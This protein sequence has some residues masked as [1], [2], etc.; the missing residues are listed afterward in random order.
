MLRQDSPLSQLGYLLVFVFSPSLVVGFCLK[1]ARCFIHSVT[2]AI[3]Y[4]HRT[5][6]LRVL[7]SIN[8][9]SFLSYRHTISRR[10]LLLSPQYSNKD[11]ETLETRLKLY[12][13]VD[14]RDQ[15]IRDQKLMKMRNWP[16]CRLPPDT[17]CTMIEYLQRAGQFCIFRT[18]DTRC[19]ISKLRLS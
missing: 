4:P 16:A 5:C 12:I 3:L 11:C 14:I 13:H 19:V 10:S 18:M 2:V 17:F 8:F 7:T 9:F 15:T 1:R 6:H